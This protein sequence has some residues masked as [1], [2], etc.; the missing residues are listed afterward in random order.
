MGWSARTELV[1]MVEGGYDCCCCSESDVS[2]CEYCHRYSCRSCGRVLCGAYVCRGG[3]SVVMISGDEGGRDGDKV[4]KS[5][6]SCFKA[7][8]K[9]IVEKVHPS[10]SPRVSPE[11]GSPCDVGETS[12][13]KDRRDDNDC[14]LGD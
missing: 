10:V 12:Y 13:G 3:G 7:S 1:A 14:G 4:I 8:R 5:F 6:K 2:F 9:V 11:P